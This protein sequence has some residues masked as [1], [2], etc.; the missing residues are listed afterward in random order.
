MLTYNF[1][2]RQDK[3]LYEYLYECIKND[4]INGTLKKGERLPSKRAL[5]LHHNIGVITVANAYNQLLL[6]GYIT[7]RERSGYYVED[8]GDYRTKPKKTQKKRGKSDIEKASKQTNETQAD[9]YSDMSEL[10]EHEYLMDFKANRTCLHFFPTSI[11]GKYMRE[12]LSLSDDTL[13]RTIPYNGLPLLRR[14]IADYLARNRGITVDPNHI[15]IGAGTEYLYG[16]LMQLFGRACTFAIESPGYKKF[17]NISASYGNPWKYVPID[18]NGLMIDALEESGADVVHV[19][20]ANHFPTGIV[21]PM[22]RRLQLF[23]W[24][25]RAKK[26]YII[27]DD[28]DSE[29]RYS[30]KFISP[31]YAEDISEKVIYINTFS[32][33][34]VP[35]LRISYMILPPKLL[36]RY[37]ETMSFYSCTVSSFEQYALARFI[38]DGHFERHMQRLKKYYNG[39]R[40]AILKAIKLSPLH[41]ISEVIERKAGTHF[42]LKVFTSL[43]EEEIKRRGTER[44]LLFSMFSDY[45]NNASVSPSHIIRNYNNVPKDAQAVQN[46]TESSQKDSSYPILVINY[47]GMETQKIDEIINKLS[48]IFPEC[49][50]TK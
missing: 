34:L 19:S 3:S 37:K 47:A 50:A 24:V 30:G 13:L 5:A 6:E 17:G 28:Y 33:S 48:S 12:A 9:M 42:L 44:D 1:S 25:N 40:L 22:T 7:S 46:G 32:K 15:I 14:A 4:I 45:S 23:E 38:E 26:R 39:Q 20:P 16:R 36:K 35:S 21:M 10:E 43:S 41:D 31:L 2:Y 49:S 11:W 8:L 29:F 27:E 18:E